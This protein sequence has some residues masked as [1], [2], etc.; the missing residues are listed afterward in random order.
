MQA[1]G[2]VEI[3]VLDEDTDV[4]CDGSSPNNAWSDPVYFK[5]KFK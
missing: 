5:G 3:H 2:L 4:P 1:N